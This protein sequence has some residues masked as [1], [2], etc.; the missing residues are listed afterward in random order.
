MTDT[1]EKK[2]RPLRTLADKHSDLYASALAKL[3]RLR[4]RRKTAL[5]ALVSVDREIDKH[6][7]QMLGAGMELPENDGPL[8]PVYDPGARIEQQ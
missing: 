4:V 3:S 1:K 2:P 8:C 6:A 5:A 7:E